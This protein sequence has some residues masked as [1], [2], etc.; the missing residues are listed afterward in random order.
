MRVAC[1]KKDASDLM[2]KEGP[3]Y[4]HSCIYSIALEIEAG[5]LV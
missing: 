5:V 4:L 2:G 1:E 3:G